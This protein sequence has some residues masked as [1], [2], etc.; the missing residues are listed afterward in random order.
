MTASGVIISSCQSLA[1]A[2]AV[3][4]DDGTL[5]RLRGTP[6][7]AAAVW[8]VGGL[9]VGLWTFRWTRRDDG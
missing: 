2:I 6:M 5:K 1:I 9:L 8:L 7:P 4:R 3:E